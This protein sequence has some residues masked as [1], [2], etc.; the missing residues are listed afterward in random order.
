VRTIHTVTTESEDKEKY[1]EEDESLVDAQERYYG[2][3]EMFSE[4][5]KIA[6]AVWGKT[7]SEEK[8]E[9]Y[10][11]REDFKIV[12]KGTLPESNQRIR[13]EKPNINDK[14]RLAYDVVLSAPKSVSMALHLEGDLRV[15]DAHMEAVQETLELIEKELAMARI[16]VNGQ[17]QVVKTGNLIAALLPHHTS[18]SG[19]M[20]LHAHT[21]IMNGTKCPDGEWRAL[22]K[23]P[24]AQAEWLGGFY[25]QKL[26]EKM[27]ELG[28][29]IYNTE[30]GFE[31]SGYSPDDLKLFSKRNTEIV[32]AVEAEGLSV[33][34]QNKKDKVLTTRKAKSKGGKSLEDKQEEWREEGYSHQVGSLERSHPIKIQPSQEA[35]TE[36]VNSAIRHLDERSVSFNRND[37][38]SYVFQHICD[39]GRDFEQI[40]RAIDE[41]KFLI[42]VGFDRF[43]TVEAIEREIETVKQ[44]MAGQGQASP[45]LA[46]PS[47]EETRLN[48]GQREAIALILTSTDPHQIVHGLSGVGKTTALGELK[49]QLEGTDIQIKGFSPTIEAAATL[50]LELGILTNTV[51]HLVLSEPNTA[52]NQLWIIDEAGMVSARQMKSILNKALEV[53]ARILLVGDKGQN[54]SIEAGSPMRSLIEHG[55][56]THSLRQIIRQQNSIQKQAVE[57]IA[58]GNGTKAL[59]LLNNNGYVTQIESKKDRANAIATQYLNLSQKERERTLIVAGTNAERLRITESIREGL[60]TE[61]KLNSESVVVQ[62]VSRQFTTEQSKQV[63]NYQEGDYIR[64]HRE[65]QSTPLKKGQLYKVEECRE[66]ELTVSSSGGRLYRFNP[67]QFK[68]KEVFYAKNFELAVGDTLRW[69]TTD[70]EKKR[71]NGQQ[72]KV[73]AIEGTTM[74]V[75]NRNGQTQS[76]SLLEPLAIDYNLVTTSYRAQGK[77][78]HRVIVSATSDP[79]SSREP[80]YVKISRQTKE[81]NVYTQDLEQLFGWVKRSNA[82]QNPLELIEEHYDNQ[83]ND[84]RTR[85]SD[86][87]VRTNRAKNAT[88][89]SPESRTARPQQNL[90]PTDIRINEYDSLPSQGR[91]QPVHQS[92][93]R[94]VTESQTERN[95]RID[96]EALSNNG[97][98][99]QQDSRQQPSLSQDEQH[100]LQFSTGDSPIQAAA[101]T[102]RVARIEK[103]IATGQAQVEEAVDKLTSLSESR[104]NTL[105]E[106]TAALA[107][108]IAR[109]WVESELVETLTTAN[110]A[111]ESLDNAVYRALEAEKLETL[112]DALGEWRLGQQLAQAITSFDEIS[113]YQLFEEEIER[114]E[115]ALSQLQSMEILNSDLEQLVTAV[116]EW[117]MESISVPPIVELAE[118]LQSLTASTQISESE[119]NE[120]QE[121]LAALTQFV[122]KYQSEGNNEQLD[123]V[124][125][126]AEAING[127]H[128][129][130]ALTNSELRTKVEELAQFLSH[131][132]ARFT[133]SKFEGMKE[134]AIAIQEQKANDAIA[135]HLEMFEQV[136]EQVNRLVQNH[137]DRQQLS[138][139][140]QS[141]QETNT[142]VQEL[143]SKKLSR[144]AQ[145]LHQRKPKAIPMPQKVEI[146]W[147]PEYPTAPPEHILPHHWKQ[148]KDSAIHPDLIALNA[149]SLSGDEVYERLLSEKLSKL[150]SGQYVT[151]PMGQELRKYEQVVEGGWWGDAGIDALSLINLNPGEKPSLSD[152]GCYKP[153][154]P[155][156]DQQKTES[157]GHT[158]FRKYENPAGTKRVP[159]LPQV[160]DELA[161]KIYVKYGINPTD[162]ERQSGFW[163]IVKQ[164]EQIPITITEGFKKTLSSLSQGFVTIGLSGVNHIYRSNENGNKLHRRQLNSEVAVFATPGREFRFAFD[165]DTKATTICNVRRDLVRGIE[166]LE[167]SG[168]IC[169]VV[170]WNPSEGKGLDDLI[171]N[172]GANAYSLAQQNAIA[173]DRD[174]RI[175]Y[176]T[177]GKRKKNEAVIC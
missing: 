172:K 71:I 160:S 116:E 64:L 105:T 87:Q 151:V 39:E 155:R 63:K 175:H 156:I 27:Q 58:D 23:E 114:L 162:A 109:D 138:Q 133:P 67:S 15:F 75:N 81:L 120:L 72:F 124:D 73:A 143:D 107:E 2:E 168:A 85:T 20:Q 14:E 163:Y 26:A 128:D 115:N 126:L 134:L 32:K 88:T 65:Y 158:E 117:Q 12:F 55:A 6:L 154:N 25:R 139:I 157:K 121:N 113:D 130:E 42:D 46:N 131:L 173:S 89:R 169:K 70:K 104:E 176:R 48:T 49:R 164:Y 177:Q 161:E 165:A 137:P 61:G 29:R 44:W 99:L 167:A 43:T 78:A 127:L 144:L 122:E 17:R 59:E 145:K 159:F 103:R 37:I 152:W 166:L 132:E 16:Q 112:S 56:T 93:D 147:Q 83:R 148:F 97:S 52:K 47:L 150:G 8:R 22:W 45:L 86:E 90:S 171:V 118:Q 91:T 33:N 18:R 108:A 141:L 111:I 36:S 82:Q 69:A 40:N 142:F 149:L 38:Y 21:L 54:S 95:G 100:Y 66:N 101:I 57:L 74:N 129:E 106:K 135:S 4:V 76:V 153:D 19:D 84:Q 13:K 35:A 1:Y 60:K 79:T 98:T 9:G 123:G 136:T 96:S 146:F 77:T 24:L 102:E 110:T 170:K 11:E 10:I 41:Q 50:Q 53:K 31:L 140:V 92:T 119:L 3:A 80:F 51:E 68:D 62:L 125:K 5:D 7:Q 30:H 174:K 94:T 34:A 28:Y